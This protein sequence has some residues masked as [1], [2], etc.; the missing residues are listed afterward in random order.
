MGYIES[1]FKSIGLKMAIHPLPA[2]TTRLLGS[3]VNIA[4]P[5]QLVKEL[6]DN[7][8]DAG[9]SSI[10]VQ[11]SP[12]CL[13][14]IRVSDNGTGIAAADFD[15]LAAPSH[16]S[17]LTSFDDLPQLA[18]QQLGFRGLALV[19][20]AN[21]ATLEVVTK[22][23]DAPV[24]TKLKIRRGIGGAESKSPVSAPIGTSVVV[25]GLFESLPARRQYQLKQTQQTQTKIKELV[26]AYALARNNVQFSI[27]VLGEQAFWKS[28]PLGAGFKETVAVAVGRDAAKTCRETVYTCP[29]M[30]ESLYTLHAILPD[31]SDSKS[32]SSRGGYIS[33]DGRPVISSRGLGK[34]LYATFKEQFPVKVAKPFMCLRITST[35][36]AY[37]VNVSSSKDEI[38]IPEESSLVLGLRTLCERFYASGGASRCATPEE[39]VH[40]NEMTTVRVRSV[41]GVN[42]ERN[43]S[44]ETEIDDADYEDIEVLAH[45]MDLPTPQPEPTPRSKRRNRIDAY[46]K[47]QSQDF[48]I[49]TDE[50]A[51][52]IV[53]SP[54]RE[55]Y[56]P[57]LQPSAASTVNSLQEESYGSDDDSSVGSP[58]RRGQFSGMLHTVAMP[59]RNRSVLDTPPAGRWNP[60]PSLPPSPE[61]RTDLQSPPPTGPATGFGIRFGARQTKITS[62]TVTRPA[63]PLRAATPRPRRAPPVYTPPSSTEARPL[64]TSFQTARQRLQETQNDSTVQMSRLYARQ[65]TPI[66]S[67][68]VA[69]ESSMPSRTSYPR[70]AQI[71]LMRSPSP[72]QDAP[73]PLSSSIISSQDMSEV[74][75]EGPGCFW[76]TPSLLYQQAPLVVR[77]GTADVVASLE[78]L[79]SYDDYVQAGRLTKAFPII[80]MEFAQIVE[81]RL[82]RMVG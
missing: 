24:A 18:S 74:H 54:T 35:N 33:V 16:T 57:V 76:L 48:E 4:S 30:G 21:M 53:S 7:A 61:P 3:T 55:P 82:N 20:I 5:C 15:K 41:F 77:T 38:I 44:N 46:F 6:L 58:E 22:A 12:N 47:A 25:S 29:A 23:K 78:Q 69:A 40:L 10:Q 32:I 43:D 8:V 75:D 70:M 45:L 60:S 50:T 80:G 26:K 28:A 64:S 27:K 81:E 39:I 62:P 73:S 59:P 52:P 14:K 37:D 11:V 56:L 9:A 63:R 65:P 1:C 2:E 67:P 19:S 79:I 66:P 31:G 13:D 34:W 71:M 49:Y 36:A 72:E 42:M 17:K 68:A 51:T